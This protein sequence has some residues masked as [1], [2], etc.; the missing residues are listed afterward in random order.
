MRPVRVLF[1]CHANLCRSP[2]AE[3]LLRHMADQRGLGHRIEVDSAGTYAMDG[4]PPH[5]ESV[6]IAREHGFD[7]TGRSRSLE[8]DDLQRFDEILAMDRRNLADIERYVRISAFG[9][10]EG[11]RARIRLARSLVSPG[12]RGAELDVPD[13]FAG[14]PDGYAR[15]Y[16]IL[17]GVC[18]RLLDEIAAPDVAR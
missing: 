14:G 1:V 4:S 3:G 16:D 6:R 7:L 8:P 5:P 18:A 17:E 11:R 2:L 15:V 10:V 12:A 9:R 13:P